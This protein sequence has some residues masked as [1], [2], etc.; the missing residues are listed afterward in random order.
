VSTFRERLPRRLAGCVLLGFAIAAVLLV[1]LIVVGSVPDPVGLAASIAAAS[2]PAMIY[3]AI[4]LWLDRYEVEPKRAIIAC[5]G[6]GAVGA[7]LFSL[8][9]GLILESLLYQGLGPAEASVVS[10]VFGA[11]L[12]E[13]TFKGLAVLILLV[14]ARDE[15]NNVLDGLVYGALVGVGF[16]MTENILYFGQAYMEG[17]FRDLGTLVLGRAAFSGFGHP[18]YTAMTG[19]AIGWARSRHGQGF[20][21][22]LVPILGWAIAVSLHMA[23][24]GGVLLGIARFGDDAGLLEIVVLLTLLVIVPAV[25]VLYA[26]ARVSARNELQILRDELRGEVDRGAITE[27]EYITIVD[28][29]RR[30]LALAAA[31]NQGGRALRARQQAF[32]QTA[33]DLAYRNYHRRRGEGSRPDQVA[34]DD[35]DRQRLSD[36]RL[37]LMARGLSGLDD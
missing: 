4:V 2:I 37:E 11:P 31:R 3:A 27:V 17:G 28:G 21:R 36:L 10:T 14:V 16:A 20:L 15:F 26:I 9:A 12:V 6:W 7:I 24:N 8:I 19:A 32:F 30:H 5:F 22:I 13:E 33:A 23:W 29:P 1:I 35:L 25:L 34:R 18:A